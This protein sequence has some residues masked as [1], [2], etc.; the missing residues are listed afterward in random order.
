MKRPLGVSIIGYFYIF[1]SIVLLFTA[2]FY[3]AGADTISIAERFGVSVVPE[4]IMRIVV[5][6]F[7]LLMAYGYMRLKKWGFWLLISYSVL[8]G[9]ISF[10]LFTNE[11][12][13][14]FIG[15]V[16][17]S[18]IVLIYTNYVKEAFF[19]SAPRNQSI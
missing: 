12:Q 6:F 14:P 15:N 4:R 18:V 8:F 3:Q 10:I 13:Q 19:K 11:P 7:S 1:G 5:A 2:I 9:F 16:V 17:F